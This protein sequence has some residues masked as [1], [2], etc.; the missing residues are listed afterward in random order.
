VSAPQFPTYEALE[1][2]VALVDEGAASALAQSQ[3]VAERLRLPVVEN[4]ALAVVG[5]RAAGR[6]VAELGTSFDGQSL[7]NN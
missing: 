4:V 1:S 3:S 6:L 2:G 7:K 5:G